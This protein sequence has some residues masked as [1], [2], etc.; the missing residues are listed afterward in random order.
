VRNPVAPRSLTVQV[1]AAG[2][3]LA[4]VV[5]VTFALLI[6]AI[7]SADRANRQADELLGAVDAVSV[8]E[9]RVIDAETGHRGFVITGQRD[10]LRSTNAAIRAIPGHQRQVRALLGEPDERALFASLV[11]TI[12]S[13]TVIWL[14]RVI[15]AAER[16]RPAAR[17]LVA[18]GEG[19]RRV[20]GMRRRFDALRASLRE[21]AD[22]GQAEARSRERAAVVLAVVGVAL[23]VLLVAV[24]TGYVMRF[25]V[26]PVRRVA[27]PRAGWPAAT[28]ARGSRAPVR[29][30]ARSA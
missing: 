11:R 16:S 21:D 15:R 17:R 28:P 10:F 22:R 29:R 9:R 4:V 24:Y 1:V 27:E 8:L 26:G 12:D 2:A 6:A 5:A 19:E 14:D 25:V 18:T 30:P 13:Y 20:N 3:V 23:A 7:E